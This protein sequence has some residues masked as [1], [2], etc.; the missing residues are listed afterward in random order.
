MTAILFGLFGLAVLIGIAWIFSSNR[1]G[2]DWK[3]VLTGLSLQIA[4]A[5][6][7]LVTP[8]GE[9]VFRWISAGFVALLGFTSAGAT[10]IFGD[11]GTSQHFGFIFAFQVLPTIVFFAAFMSVLYHLG[12]MQT[13]VKS[14]AWVIMKVMRVSGAETLSV[15][16]NAFIGQ[17]EAPLVVKPYIAGMTRSELLCLMVGGMA[18]IAGGVMAAERSGKRAHTFV[19]GLREDQARRFALE[20]ARGAFP[21]RRLV[22]AFQP[23]RYTRTRDLFED[24][25]KVLST[26]DVLLL[27]EVYPAGEAPIVAADGR[28]LARAI[29]VAGKV[30]PIFVETTA[31]LPQGIFNAAHDGDVV[32]IMGAGSIG[33]VPAKLVK[34]A[35]S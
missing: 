19:G 33:Q 6:F 10:L 14:M 27:T 4:F 34:S 7:V 12:V 2:V 26:V 13:V 31:E 3:L 32:L 28:A 21:G 30:E 9:T 17:T 23:H 8:W 22:L 35:E 18:T 11:L 5:L 24:F 29:R 20:A 25:V 16:A 15:C 1:R